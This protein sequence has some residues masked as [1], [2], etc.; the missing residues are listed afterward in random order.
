MNLVISGGRVIDPANGVDRVADLFVGGE[1]ILGLDEAP[2]GFVVDRKLDVQGQIVIPGL[3]DLAAR[4]R[5]PGQEHKATIATETRAAA[6]GGVTSLCCLPDTNPVVDSPAEVK[7]I[8]QRA[9]DAGF[10]RVHVIGALTADLKGQSLSEMA[11]L[12][13][14]GCVGVTNALQPMISALVLRRAMEYA[15]SQDLTVFLPPHDHALANAGCAHE[16]AAATRLGLPGIPTAAETAALG[17]LLALVEETGARTHFCRLSTARGVNMVAR[18]AYDGLPVTADVCA[19]Q[20]FLTEDDIGDFNSLCHT[21]PP[22]RTRQDR[23]G[24]RQGIARGALTAICSDHQPH[25]ID[26]KQAPFPATEPG[27]SA[28]ETLLALTLRLVEERVLNL[29]D[30]IARI[31][32]GPAAV[33]GIDAGNL[34]V[35]R[36]ADLCIY[37]PD[38]RWTLTPQALLSQGKNTPFLGRSFTGRVTHTLLGGRIV[39]QAHAT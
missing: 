19:H 23:D 10:C 7:F 16:G 8:Q 14:A 4:L 21:L 37:Q 25:D 33:L 31:T 24:L 1:Q 12:K 22:L 26:A 2:P 39:Y 15:A 5:E 9:R 30:A 18:A 38:E 20:L 11:A 17:Q 3:V 13:R 32:A 35:G 6:A 28:V 27:I 36:Y 29:S 34:S